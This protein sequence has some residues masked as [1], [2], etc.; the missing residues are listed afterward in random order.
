MSD[1]Q[2]RCILKFS[3][4]GQID[5]FSI[6]ESYIQED[7]K[8]CISEVIYESFVMPADEDY[9]TARFLAQKSR[10][11]AFFWSAAQALEKYLKAFLLTR[12]ENVRSYRHCIKSL[13][14]KAILLENDLSNINTAMHPSV[15][16][17]AE[18]FCIPAG[19]ELSVREFIEL[20]ESNG[21]PDNRY[22]GN[23]LS[24]NFAYL[25][26]LDSFIFQLRKSIGASPIDEN[27]K[28]MNEVFIDCFNFYNPWFSPNNY[29]SDIYSKGLR[30]GGYTTK[31]D[32][33]S[34]HNHFYAKDIITWLHK[35]M[36]L[37]SST[38]EK[39]GLG[40]KDATH[41]ISKKKVQMCA[42]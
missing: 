12:G 2:H 3:L 13:Y 28:R 36:M 34:G 19:K 33:L 4:E 17:D 31:I 1:A 21:H 14:D 9:I 24:F 41:L 42:K 29:L 8:Y 10:Y 32:R 30:I 16:M 20:I 11:R 26:A 35:K 23:G 39:F 40:K 37:P 27:L 7:I 6:R 22:N 5:N 15:A 18:K 38:I 25:F